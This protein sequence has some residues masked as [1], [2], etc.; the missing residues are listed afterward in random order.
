MTPA[1]ADNEFV[2]MIH[3][4][5]T[6]MKLMTKLFVCAASCLPQLCLADW[7]S[8]QTITAV[9]NWTAHTPQISLT[10]S[11]GVPNCASQTSAGPITFRTG[12]MG[13]T[14]DSLKG[15]LATALSAYLAGK[16][17]MIW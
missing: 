6:T 4:G 1:L 7:S 8:C 11:P 3:A 9:T 2:F 12:M 14:D 5:R 10:L 13:V 17:V 16:P 15:Y